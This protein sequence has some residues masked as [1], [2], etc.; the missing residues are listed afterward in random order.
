MGPTSAG[1]TTVAAALAA[2]LRAAGAPPLHLD[3]D[4]IRDLFGT[5]VDFGAE[6]RLRVVTALVALARKASDGGVA[7]VVSALT[8]H[9]DA[10]RLVYGLGER[11]TLCYLRCPIDVCA[12]RDPKGLYLRARQGEIDTLIGYNTPYAPPDAPDM[13][14]DTAQASVDDCVN[15]IL[16]ACPKLLPIG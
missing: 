11:L 10:R 14:I 7:V 16:L 13:V 8:A 12:G 6:S 3:G 9:E 5:A 15:A 4:D 1:K 2:R